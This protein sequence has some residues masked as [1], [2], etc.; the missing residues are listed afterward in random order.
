MKKSKISILLLVMVMILAISAVS[1]ADIDDTSDSVAQAVDES[2]V[3]EVASSDVDALAATDNTDVLSAGEQNFTQLQ[4]AVDSGTVSMSNDYV[5][6]AGENTISINRDVTI[7]GN[8]FKIDGNNLGG[9][10]NVNSGYTLTLTGVTLING[11]SQNGA[12]VYVNDGAVLIANDVTFKENIASEYDGGAI[13]TVGG[14]ITLT[15]CVLDSNDVTKLES[16]AAENHGGT[17]IYA[18]DATVSLTNTD[19]IN[20]GRNFNRTN[21]DLVNGALNLL[22]SDTTIVGCLFG[23]NTGIYGGAIY[24]EVGK[25]RVSKSSFAAN[26]AYS[27]GAIQLEGDIE[28]NIEDSTFTDNNKAVGIGSPGYAASGGA[29]FV[30]YTL[31]GSIDN[32]TVDGSYSSQGGAID[33]QTY[34]PIT[35][36]NSAFKNNVA[37]SRGGAI[38]LY[39]GHLNVDN[40][41]FVNN[42]ANDAGAIWA[43]DNIDIS[44]CEFTDNT[45]T[46]NGGAIFFTKYCTESSVTD[47]KFT[48]NTV[49]GEGN[50]IFGIN[51]SKISLSN[52]SLAGSQADIVSEGEIISQINVITYNAAVHYGEKVNLTATIT[53]DNGNLIDAANFYFVVDNA[54]YGPAVYNPATGKYE[55]EQEFNLPLGTYEIT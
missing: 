42:N 26:N 37:E 44:G 7:I 12:A 5:R 16:S 27:G 49:G 3:E 47:S 10:F 35:I 22:N 30:K 23:N 20:N 9:I 6:Q 54:N 48:G 11:N 43:F 4:T 18:K 45:A 31:E 17:A 38:F 39:D 40:C 14:T 33:V 19:V 29:I 25:I 13:Y 8:D 1:A 46:E 21:G 50:A 51:G 53:D 24:A 36:K 52:N 2:P 34:S 55:F 32:I 28:F 15:N 41:T